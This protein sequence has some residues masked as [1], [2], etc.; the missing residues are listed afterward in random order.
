[1]QNSFSRRLGLTRTLYDQRFSSYG[2]KTTRCLKKEEFLST[3]W[4]CRHH[5]MV[6]MTHK[7]FLK[8][9]RRCKIYFQEDWDQLELSTINS[10]WAMAKKPQGVWKEQF[11]GTF[12]CCRHHFIVKMTHKNFLKEL[13]R[14]K[15]HFQEDWDQL[16]LSTI[17]GFWVMV[18][19]PQG[20]WK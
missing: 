7:K 6:K 4:C 10:F 19:K 5:F 13:K 12:W 11:L 3:Y 16:E 1:M 14:C 20:V 18:K 2:K 17:N 8:E 9:L 15:I